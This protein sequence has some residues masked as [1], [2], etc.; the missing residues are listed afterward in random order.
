MG[1]H[2]KLIPLIKFNYQLLIQQ[3][4]DSPLESTRVYWRKKLG[5]SEKIQNDSRP[6]SSILSCEIKSVDT[7]Q[8]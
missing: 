2:I 4:V 1:F 3:M 6:L 7:I 8:K 5:Y